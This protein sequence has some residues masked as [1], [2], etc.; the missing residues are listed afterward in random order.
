[1]LEKIK[2]GFKKFKENLKENV[3]ESNDGA[4]LVEI[5]IGI[6]LVAVLVGIVFLVINKVKNKG[7]EA[8]DVI[9]EITFKAGEGGGATP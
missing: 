6:A 1:M 3:V 7:E 9:N 2:N 8:G 4:E 5:I